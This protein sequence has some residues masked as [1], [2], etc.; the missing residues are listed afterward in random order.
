MKLFSMVV[1]QIKQVTSALIKRRVE[2]WLSKRVPSNFQHT[3]SRRNIFIMPTRFG[4]A[5][6]IFIVLLFLLGTN[7]QNNIIL[8]LCYLLA[9]LFITV[10]LHSFYNF[11]QLTFSSSAK[12]FTF[13]KQRAYFPIVIES[14][15]AHF[16][17]NFQFSE[18]GALSSKV[19]LEQCPVGESQVLLPFYAERRGVYKVGRVN[20]F[21]EYSLGLFVTWARLDFSHQVVIFPEPKKLSTHQNYLSALDESEHSDNAYQQTS[22]GI[23]DFA[24]LK[25]YI[26]GESHARIA[27][28]QLARGQGKLSKHYQNQQGSLLWLKLSNMPSADLETK[29]SFLCYLVMQYSKSEHDFGLCLD[30]AT[31]TK[32]STV[33]N[34]QSVKIAPSSGHQH[35]QQC[36]IALAEFTPRLAWRLGG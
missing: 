21:S 14:N 36:L 26:S 2:H 19:K 27:W 13:A 16:D 4:F 25:N 11:S 29:L 28:K 18:Q 9:S 24:E 20:V 15:K 8:L 6:L 23:D 33:N 1:N 12:Q 7:Y 10:M 31:F 5:Y 3:L 17:L 32:D 35:Q 30:L 22:V 34:G